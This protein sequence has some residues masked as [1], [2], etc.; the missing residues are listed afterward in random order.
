MNAIEPIKW[1]TNTKTLTLLDQTMLP[2]E[3]TYLE[4][5]DPGDVAVAIRDLVVRG[6]PAIGC[7]AAYGVALAAN[8]YTGVHR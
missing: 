2:K 7:A 3:E 8:Q 1:D 4:Y 6:A 5:T